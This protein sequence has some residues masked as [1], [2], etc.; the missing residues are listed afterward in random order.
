MKCGKC[1]K[2]TNVAYMC[3]HCKEFFCENHTPRTAH[4][5]SSATSKKEEE[6]IE[7]QEPGSLEAKF[8][9]V[10]SLRKGSFSIVFSLVVLD[11]ILRLLARFKYSSNIEANFYVALV[12]LLLNPYISPLL[13]LIVVYTVL[14]VTERKMKRVRSD[15]ADRKQITLRYLFVFAVYFLLAIMLFPGVIMWILILT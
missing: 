2:E 12:S 10:E 7:A 14:F 13:F 6:R 15:F 4:D 9:K 8:R 5:C 11:Q 1:K 3:L